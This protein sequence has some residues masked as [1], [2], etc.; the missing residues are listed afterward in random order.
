MSKGIVIRAMLGAVTVGGLTLG[1]VTSWP[2]P[3]DPLVSPETLDR[4]KNFEDFGCSLKKLGSVTR[5]LVRSVF[6]ASADVTNCES[7]EKGDCVVKKLGRVTL[8]VSLIPPKLSETSLAAGLKGVAS[9]LI[10]PELEE[11]IATNGG[12]VVSATVLLICSIVSAGTDTNVGK[13]ILVV[14][15]VKVSET[16]SS[17]NVVKLD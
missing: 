1:K 8:V 5:V 10:S 17:K 13:V 15:A 3:S 7:I 14:G 12:R 2:A 9:I 11:E 6:G 16:S 4:S